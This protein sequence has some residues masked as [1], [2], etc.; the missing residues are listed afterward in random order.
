L[1]LFSLIKESKGN[2]H[3]L[4]YTAAGDWSEVDVIAYSTLHLRYPTFHFFSFLI[5]NF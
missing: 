4:F 3:F 5:F 1:T 2:L